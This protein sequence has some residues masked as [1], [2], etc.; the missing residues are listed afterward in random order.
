MIDEL[1]HLSRLGLLAVFIV[2]TI[3]LFGVTEAGLM[4][5]R[6]SRHGIDDA[7]RSQAITIEA[8]LLGLLALLLGFAFVM[9]VGR[10]EARRAVAIEEV[11]SIR[12][13]NARSQLLAAPHDGTASHLLRDYVDARIDFVRAGED[14]DALAAAERRADTLLDRLW[15][16]A[17]AIAKVNSD[18]VRT[19]YYVSALNDVINDHANRAASMENHVPDVILWLIYSV[20]FAA[21]GMAGFCCG[22]GNGRHVFFRLIL[23]LTIVA[24][25]Q[26]IMDL[27]RP[28]SGYILVSERHLAQLQDSMRSGDPLP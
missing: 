4:L 28:R 13:A 3:V 5:G 16:E 7:T 19:G 17:V 2:S 20:A 11:D 18:E 9:A 26:V 12:T 14:Q 15:A 22:F 25:V 6:R 10:Y 27:D 23:V 1:F 24:T 21:L 8:S